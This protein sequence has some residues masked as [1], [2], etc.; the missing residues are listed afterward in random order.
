MIFKKLLLFYCFIYT[1]SAYGTYDSGSRDLGTS[2][3]HDTFTVLSPIG[4]NLSAPGAEIA[5]D[6]SEVD[7]MQEL[8]PGA[9]TNLETDGATSRAT[10]LNETRSLI[11]D[12]NRRQARAGA[13]GPATRLPRHILR[14]ILERT[15]FR[16]V[17]RSN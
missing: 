2:I 1:Y 10:V 12:D 6:D 4:G 5:I 17:P 7:Y 15:T 16:S 11:Q 9:L 3:S 13:G 14:R 8:G